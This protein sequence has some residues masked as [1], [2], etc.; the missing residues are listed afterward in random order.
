MTTFKA[1]AYAL[2][3]GAPRVTRGQRIFDVILISLILGN[4]LAVFLSTVQSLG[5]QY[6]RLFFIFEL[7]SVAVFTLELIL[8]FWVSDLS[9]D[10][11]VNLA[12][13]RFW[14]NPYILADLL[15]ILGFYLGVLFSVD[16]RL[17]WLLRLLRV[18]KISCYIGSLSLLWS[19]IKQEFRPMLSAL[20]I[21]SILVLFATV[22]IYLLEREG[23]PES[24]GNLPSCLWWTVV[25]VSTVG[26]GDAVPV[27]WLGRILG[28]VI[29]LLGI[30]MVAL[31][32]GMLASRF[33]E[34][35]HRK[36]ELFRRFVEDSIEATGGIAEELLEQ[37]RLELFIGRTEAKS[38][39]ANC[40][41]E[42]QRQL[43]FCPSCG[44]KLPGRKPT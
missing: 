8:R 31:P 17:F 7:V 43:N 35:M 14:I 29:M 4:V 12:R 23:Q 3:E 20:A 21:I 9:Q 25:T 32:A 27:T 36:Q 18:L 2:L 22:G 44:S 37:R 39:I 10:T 5:A 15:A 33:S 26:Y 24:F 19:V 13:W 11:T 41:D 16:L 28:T 6:G 42:S 40:I 38:I 34:V 1:K 30:G